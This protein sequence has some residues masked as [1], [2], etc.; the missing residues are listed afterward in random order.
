MRATP[1]LAP[2]GG[3]ETTKRIGRSGKAARALPVKTEIAQIMAASSASMGMRR[4]RI[5]VEPPGMNRPGRR[6]ARDAD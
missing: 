4:A 5:I 6:V 2:P 3:N 1:S